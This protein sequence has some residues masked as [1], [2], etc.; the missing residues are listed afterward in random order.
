MIS[1]NRWYWLMI[2]LHAL[3]PDRDGVPLIRYF[4]DEFRILPRDSPGVDFYQVPA[5]AS[6]WPPQIQVHREAFF[7]LIA[8]DQYQ[9][10]P[11]Q[12]AYIDP[13]RKRKRRMAED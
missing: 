9:F 10:H 5:Q 2:G 11:C 13:T 7:Q 4:C 8:F 1:N 6:Q 3:A 12:T